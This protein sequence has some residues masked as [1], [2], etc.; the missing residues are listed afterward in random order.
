MNLSDLHTFSLVGATGTISG[1]AQ[2]L[3]VPKSTVSRR[4]RRLEDALG[5]ELL[6]RTA[7]SVTLTKAGEALLRRTQPALQELENAKQ[8]LLQSDTEPSGTLRLTTTPSFG[9]SHEVIACVREFGVTYPK[10][11][12]DMVLTMRVVNL[13][14][15]GFDV[16]LLLHPTGELPGSALL[17]SRHLLNF[18]WGI[19]GSP[20]YLSQ[21]GAPES[22]EELEDHRMAIHPVVDRAAKQPWHRKGQPT[23]D[24]L[25]FDGARWLVDDSVALER[26]ALAGA[27]LVVLETMAA[28]PLVTKGELIR[29][30]PEYERQSGTASLV[31]PASRHLAPRVRA[32]IQCAVEHFAGEPQR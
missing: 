5:T 24:Q 11:R 3:G 23:S 25:G 22:V 17:M 26:L 14:E 30:L 1:A 32:F 18:R 10:I 27:G 19:Y 8:A 6:R 12:V 20:D 29:V 7:R 13:I 31:W 2:R 21:M 28:D 9:Q 4:V 16:G 15:E